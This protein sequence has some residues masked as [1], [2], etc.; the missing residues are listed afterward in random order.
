M[1]IKTINELTETQNLSDKYS[2]CADGSGKTHKF[3]LDNIINPVYRVIDN[4]LNASYDGGVTYTPVSDYISSYFRWSDKN[5]IQISYDNK[6]WTDLSGSFTNNIFIKG[7]VKTLN[8]LPPKTTETLGSMY[9]VGEQP[10]YNMYV[11]TENGW[12]DNGQFQSISAGVV[13]ETGNSE[14][15]VMSQKAVTE[16]LTELKYEL[17]MR[18]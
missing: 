4:K 12:V 14:T 9:M 2:I 16:K 10:P 7:Y 1:N 18:L 6:T 11:L 17:G 13:Q 3:A 5:T 8:D 15:E